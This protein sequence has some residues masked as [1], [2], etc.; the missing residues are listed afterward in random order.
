MWLVTPR[1]GASG[2]RG[3]LPDLLL[4][5]HYAET[6]EATAPPPTRGSVMR[7][8]PTLTGSPSG[9]H[10]Q[11][12][13]TR[14]SISSMAEDNDAAKEDIPTGPPS[15]RSRTRA[16]ECRSPS[17]SAST[18]PHSICFVR[19]HLIACSRRTASRSHPED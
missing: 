15:S 4:G 9:P 13:K 14:S 16:A 19:F 3:H 11:T 18:S 1:H 2:S 12:L 7:R 10:W 17:S 8:H 5:P 6:E